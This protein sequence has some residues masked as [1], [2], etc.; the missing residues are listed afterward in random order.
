LLFYYAKKITL[1]DVLLVAYCGL[2]LIDVGTDFSIQEISGPSRMVLC[3]YGAAYFLRRGGSL[4]SAAH[5]AVVG[6]GLAQVWLFATLPAA[7]TGGRLAY[8]GTA[9]TSARDLLAMF[10]ILYLIVINRGVF[11]ATLRRIARLQIVATLVLMLLTGSRQG[12]I[13]GIGGVWIGAKLIKDGVDLW[14]VFRRS[15][16]VLGGLAV[17]FTGLYVVYL[18]TN[19]ESVGRLFD[20]SIKGNLDRV[21]RYVIYYE[22][23]V[24]NSSEMLMGGVDIGEMFSEAG[25]VQRVAGVKVGAPH[26]SF[27]GV[28]LERGLIPLFFYASFH[29]LTMIR[30]IDIHNRFSGSKT[31]GALVS[32]IFSAFIIGMFTNYFTQVSSCLAYIFYSASGLYINFGRDLKEN[33]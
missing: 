9:N 25:E 1:I 22:F 26:N 21:V 27:L 28:G 8:V 7:F 30:V 2:V 18:A 23:L 19:I 5:V 33:K 29:I 31:S 32:I 15:L 24:E 20:L 11:S 16:Q 12:I 17:L 6:I 3:F 10:S 4:L 13:L 14:V